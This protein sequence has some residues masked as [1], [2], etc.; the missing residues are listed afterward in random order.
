MK[1]LLQGVAA[2]A[3]GVILNPLRRRKAELL[4]PLPRVTGLWEVNCFRPAPL[5]VTGP[6]LRLGP[7]R[8]KDVIGPNLVVNE[9]LS[10]LLQCGLSNETSAITIWYVLLMDASPSVAADDTMASHAGWTENENYDEAVRQT[11]VAGSESGQSVD[12]SASKATYTMD[13]DSDS[14]GGAALVSVSTKGGSTGTLYCGG[15][16]TGGNKPV[17]DNDTLEVQA[18]LT[19]ADDG[20]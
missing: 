20:V 13:T 5:A 9:G 16:F 17:D 8:W 18:T 10:Y 2:A 6:Q 4:F 19:Q 7:L 11:W 1:K 3:S 15:P 12:N 14:V